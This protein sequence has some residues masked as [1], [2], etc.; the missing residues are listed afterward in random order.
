MQTIF[1]V[2]DEIQ[3][4]KTG[5]I[6][7]VHYGD[8]GQMKLAILADDPISS[9]FWIDFLAKRVIVVTMLVVDGHI[10]TTR[11]H[12]QTQVETQI[13][14]RET[15][16]PRDIVHMIEVLET[17]EDISN[18]VKMV[19]QLREKILNHADGVAASEDQPAP[20]SEPCKLIL[21]T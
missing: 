14:L 19:S 7:K 8:Q 10:K 13:I 15:Y 12:R 6:Y 2:L 1:D 9:R 4:T 18:V 21:P 16:I 20:E 5:K 17:E 11:K 3:T